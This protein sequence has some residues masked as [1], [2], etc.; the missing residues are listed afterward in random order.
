KAEVLRKV[1]PRAQQVKVWGLPD[2]CNPIRVRLARAATE[3]AGGNPD[4]ILSELPQSFYD[5]AA[6]L[7]SPP[8]P[9]PEPEPEGWAEWFNF[10]EA[11]DFDY[12]EE[13]DKHD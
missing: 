7:E 9:E 1:G 5:A 13:P 3:R 10:P 2:L 4:T 6:A 12:L 11:E 8:S